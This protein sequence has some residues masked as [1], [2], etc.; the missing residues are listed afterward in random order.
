MKGQNLTLC[1]GTSSSSP[2]GGW[3]F[4]SLEDTRGSGD[5]L[6]VLECFCPCNANYRLARRSLISLYLTYRSFASKRNCAHLNT[7]IIGKRAP[8]GA[9]AVDCRGTGWKER[10]IAYIDGNCHSWLRRF[11]VWKL[12]GKEKKRIGARHKVLRENDE[13]ARSAWGQ[14]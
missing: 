7:P 14:R 6:E 9:L 5:V 12:K 1:N 8:F 4:P 11:A 10:H 3:K 13:V 2:T